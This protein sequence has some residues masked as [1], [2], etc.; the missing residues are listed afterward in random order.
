MN[1]VSVVV[2]PQGVDVRIGNM[3][4]V[5]LFAGEVGR[6]P[7]L[8]ELVFAFDFAFGLRRGGV[9][10]ADVIE[11]ESPAQL[12]E[13][14]RVLSEEEAVVI[15]IELE[16]PSV[17]QESSGQEVVSPGTSKPATAGHFKT[18]QSEVRFL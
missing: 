12:R 17:S 7:A 18:S 1:F 14:V 11:L 13:G 9:A 15:D 16:G 2:R 10:Q 5:D 3:D 8:P 4:F 6:Q